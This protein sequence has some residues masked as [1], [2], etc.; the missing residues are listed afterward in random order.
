MERG[1]NTEL[2]QEILKNSPVLKGFLRE[3]MTPE[4]FGTIGS[5][6]REIPLWESSIDATLP[7]AFYTIT[8]KTMNIEDVIRNQQLL[9]FM[10]FELKS[11]QNIMLFL[12]EIVQKLE[13]TESLNTQLAYRRNVAK[14]MVKATLR[15]GT[16]K[17]QNTDYEDLRKTVPEPFQDFIEGLDE[18]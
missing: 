12:D 5:Y 11:Y 10:G 13:E 2:G 18:I 6:K 17:R 1:S 8:Y 14:E 4:V 3:E 16:Q 15:V 7:F 9:F